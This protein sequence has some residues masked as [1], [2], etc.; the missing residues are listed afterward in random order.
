[1]YEQMYRLGIEA[2]AAAVQYDFSTYSQR[3]LWV[4]GEDGLG[5]SNYPKAEVMLVLLGRFSRLSPVFFTLDLH[6]QNLP[7]QQTM[8]R[9]V[10]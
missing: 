8:Y 5:H 3:V 9:S 7:S 4:R 2:A 6:L 10:T 1:M